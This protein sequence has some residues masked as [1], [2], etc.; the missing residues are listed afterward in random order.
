MDEHAQWE[1]RQYA[2]TI[3]D[4]IVSP[5]FPA[6]WEAFVDYRVHSMD[7]TRLDQAVIAR[8][9]EAGGIPAT[10]ADFLAAQDPS[11]SQLKRCRERD[12]CREKLVRLGLVLE[13]G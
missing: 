2:R 11:W 12:E 10:E 1:I 9:T 7:L 6:V 8:L 4:E 13:K 5:L 3:G